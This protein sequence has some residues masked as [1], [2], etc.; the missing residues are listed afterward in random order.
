M[1]IVIV[2]IF[3]IGLVLIA[4]EKYT[5]VNKAA[6][7]IF[8]GTIGW[9]LY[10]CYGTDFVMS[11][12]SKEYMEFLGGNVPDHQTVKYFIAQNIFL[13]YVGKASE[14]VLFLLSTMAVVEILQNNGCFD[15]IAGWLRTRNSKKMLWL[16][17]LIT[18]VISAN[19]DN[20]TTTVMM[21]T[22]MHGIVVSHRHRIMYGCAI[23]ISAN[24]GGALTVIGDASGLVLW[25]SDLVT[26]T[27][28][29]L[30]MAVPCLLSWM[31]PVYWIGRK[32]PL[33]VDT[34]WGG[35]PYRGN[36]TRLNVWQRIAMLF[37][38]IG[39]LWFIPTFHNITKLSP[40]IGALCVLTLLWTF[41]EIMNRKLMNTGL[42][43]QS[44]IP[45]VLQ[46]GVL[47][48]I[49]FVLGVMLAVGV[50]RETGITYAI[51]DFIHEHLGNLFVVG[52]I[53]QLLSSILDSFAVAVTMFSFHDMSGIV[54]SGSHG[55]D[56]LSCMQ[57]G[58]YWKIVSFA[59]AAGG[60]I[61]CIGSASGMALMKMERIKIGWY[62][63]N[64]GVVSMVCSLISLGIMM[65]II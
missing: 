52:V 33:R 56:I 46:Y 51:F 64:V 18:F 10:I 2:T 43:T 11:Q 62:F 29:S 49:M 5:N 22:I 57:S 53:V 35:I 37:V 41:N 38:G 34:E 24:C 28:Y 4:T 6:T 50:V 8:V 16:M 40:F 20:L 13:K 63:R 3:I 54:A 47:Q 61:L 30:S 48:M 44:R 60:N 25:N 31:V 15:F 19:L 26:A 14:I 27:D 21:L 17:S 65:C 32:L 55:S 39:G 12:H 36:D 9:I 7:A 45:M 23:V 59:S 42:M 58:A 1:T